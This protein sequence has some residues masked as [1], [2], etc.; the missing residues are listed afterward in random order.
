MNEVPVE[1]QPA[2]HIRRLYTCPDI[3]LGE[4]KCA[5]RLQH[6]GDRCGHLSYSVFDEINILFHDVN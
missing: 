4:Y 6:L 2:N 3:R 1:Q 5:L